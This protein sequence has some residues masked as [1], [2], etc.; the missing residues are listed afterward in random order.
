LEGREGAC[1]EDACE[2][3][4]SPSSSDEATISMSTVAALLG[5]LGCMPGRAMTLITS[6]VG[7]QFCGGQERPPILAARGWE[8][9]Q[10]KTRKSHEKV[11]REMNA[12][13]AHTARVK[14]LL[15]GTWWVVSNVWVWVA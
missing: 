11:V 2:H 3:G 15:G 13:T 8:E 14:I 7:V 12:D 1:F 10:R 9:G 4:I 5:D 6:I